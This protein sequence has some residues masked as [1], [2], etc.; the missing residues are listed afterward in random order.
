MTDKSKIVFA[1]NNAHKL[2]ELRAIVGDRFAVLSAAEAGF[3][4]EIPE[5]SDTL[6]DNAIQ[7]ADFLYRRLGLTCV[8]DDTGLEVDA[9]DG[10]PGVYTARYA[11]MRGYGADHDSAANMHALLDDLADVADDNRTARFRTVIALVGD[12]MIRTFEGTVEG[13]IA[14][15]PRGTNGFGYDPVFVPE[16]LA[17]TFAQMDNTAKNAI[18]HRGRAVRKLTEALTTEIK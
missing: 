12:D 2:D 6:R 4:G 15:E 11:A 7:K 1:T 17:T 5:D 3:S 18:S 8:A 16:G 14:R 9:L 10:K 13:V